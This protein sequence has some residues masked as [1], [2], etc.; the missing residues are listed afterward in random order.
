MKNNK[1]NQND[2]DGLHTISIIGWG[3]DEEV[4]GKF[5]GKE[6][7]TKHKVGYWIVRNSW[8]NKWGI[9]GYLHLAM[10]PF[11]KNCQ[12][13]V[14]IPI[15]RNDNTNSYQGGFLLFTPTLTPTYPKSIENFQENEISNIPYYQGIIIIILVIIIL[16]KIFSF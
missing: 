2:A 5:I 9:D 12:L 13:E 10:Y 6:K 16:C 7:G 1:I 11:N 14:S 8:G 4:D 15:L 3:V